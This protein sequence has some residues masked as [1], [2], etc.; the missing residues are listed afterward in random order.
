MTLPKKYYEMI[1]DVLSEVGGVSV[2]SACVTQI[3]YALAKE[4]KEDNP[5]FDQEDF[6]SAA[7]IDTES[8]T[9]LAVSDS[10]GIYAPQEF[11]SQYE[12][13][14]KNASRDDI[15]T[16]LSGPDEEWY[17]EA[18]SDIESNA[19]IEIDGVKWFIHQSGDIWLVHE[20]APDEIWENLSQ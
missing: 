7:G 10:A 8:F 19:Y 4:F 11:V 15:D 20:D 9:M 14:L 1:A 3:A 16:V 18:W 12:D 5:R 2:N 17:W 6:L 13:E